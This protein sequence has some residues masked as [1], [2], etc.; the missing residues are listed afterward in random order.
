M[1]Q[2]RHYQSTSIKKLLRVRSQCLILSMQYVYFSKLKYRISYGQH[3]G[4]SHRE[5]KAISPQVYAR[6]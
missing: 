1:I 2:G 4:D 6:T 3:E 5:F